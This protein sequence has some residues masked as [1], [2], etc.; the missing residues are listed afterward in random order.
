MAMYLFI[1]F[2]TY[3]ILMTT[4]T[5][6]K[7]CT[8]CIVTVMLKIIIKAIFMFTQ[9]N[10]IMIMT[11]IIMNTKQ[12]IVTLVNII[13][14]MITIINT[15]VTLLNMIITMMTTMTIQNVQ[16]TITP[17]IAMTLRGYLTKVIPV[18]I[19][20]YICDLSS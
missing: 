7:M 2:L 4:I 10:T 16:S 12:L 18:F 14:M 5:G 11:T 19:Y 20:M 15:T 13:T 3:K 17:L 9:L 6:T 8:I 1:P